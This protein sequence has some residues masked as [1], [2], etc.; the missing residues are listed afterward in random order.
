M[1]ELKTKL[2]LKDSVAILTADLAD[3]NSLNAITS[4]TTVLLSTA[5][6]YAQ[7]GAPM[8]AACV[9]GGAHY[10]DLTGEAPFVREMVDKHFDEA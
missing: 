9:S 2:Q 1:A 6:P 7:I 5:G 8:V 3:L 10:C 4:Q